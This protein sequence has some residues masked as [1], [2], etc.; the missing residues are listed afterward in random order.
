MGRNVR[1]WVPTLLLFF[2]GA[3]VGTLSVDAGA[4]LSI[5]NPAVPLWVKQVIVGVGSGAFVTV[6]YK[7]FE[8]ADF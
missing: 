8:R 4:L 5:M 7:V 2:A 6:G 1:F 3:I